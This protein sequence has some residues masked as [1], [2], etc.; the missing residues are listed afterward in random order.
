MAANLFVNRLYVL[1]EGGL[2]AYDEQFH[3]G[4]NI[5][6]GENSS[7]KS[8]ITHLL[9]YALGGEY[10]NFVAQARSCSRVMVEVETD[11]AVLTLSRPIEKDD[12]GRVLP[13]RGMT[14]YWGSI[15]Q[16]L[17]SNCESNYF[18]YSTTSNKR[19]FSNELFEVM[20]MPIVQGDSNIT[21]HQ[22]LRLLYIDQESPTS[23][24]FY[25]EQFDKQTTREAVAD[26]LL[27]IFDSKATSMDDIITIESA[28]SEIKSDI[29]SVESSLPKDQRSKEHI[30][31]LIRQKQLDIEQLEEDIHRK[32]QGE[33]VSKRHKSETMQQMQL[34]KALAHDLDKAERDENILT[35]DIEDTK[36]F[37]D[38]LKRKQK[39]LQNS[40]ST[41]Q[42]L[43]NLQL[44]YCPECLS[45]LPNDVPEGTCRLCKSPIKDKLGITQAKRLI[46]ELSFQI[47]ESAS[48][49]EQD[50][51]R[52]DQLKAQRL[53]LRRKH[54]SARKTLDQMLDNVRSTAEEEIED[55]IYNKGMA[56]GE[57]LQLYD[58][59]ERAEYY[60]Q[61][62]ER[63]EQL[64]SDLSHEERLIQA[65]TAGQESRRAQVLSKIQEHGVYFLQHDKERQRDFVNSRPSD[66]HVDFANN[67]VYLS[68][69]YSKY[70]A[71]SAFFLKIVARFSLFFASLDIPWMRYPHFIFADNMEDK[72]IEKERAQQFQQTLIERLK[73]YPTDSYQLIYTTSYITPELDQSDYVVG[74][75]YTMRN[76]SLKNV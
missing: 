28:I 69:K 59:M 74:D 16:A 10:T 76:K 75:H 33:E 18:G 7:G 32:R 45:P 35:H 67:L 42:I 62:I 73:S 13:K 40:V 56:N 60:E 48:I 66:F 44:E 19:S 72:G 52:L 41:R 22:L 70:S 61:L 54:R 49:H 65:K 34:V 17:A 51:K 5:I 63:K 58:M 57:L 36:M 11:G 71:S 50:I 6:R 1:T 68:D 26:L 9:F 64:E 4:V 37:I 55:L 53:S 43:G 38:E 24:L 29:R 8:T 14:V 47:K 20:G 46:A 12:E 39:A 27:G 21:M 3:H 25:Y 30:E 23:S 2:V 15:D 31:S